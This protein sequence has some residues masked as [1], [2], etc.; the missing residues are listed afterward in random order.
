MNNISLRIERLR[1]NLLAGR[2]FIVRDESDGQGEK[3]VLWGQNAGV[4]PSDTELLA[5][6]LSVPSAAEVSLQ[7]AKQILKN[8]VP[9]A[10]QDSAIV[11]QRIA[12]A[13]RRVLIEMRN[14]RNELNA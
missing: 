2:D 3:L 9:D 4:Q 8:D 6:D 11:Q 13:T 5:V 1:P 12:W 7:K 14:E 10:W